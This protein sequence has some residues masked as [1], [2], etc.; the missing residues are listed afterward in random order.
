MFAF[1]TPFD[2][3]VLGTPPAFI[4]SQDRTLMFLSGFGLLSG[5][6]FQSVQFDILCFTC[7]WVGLPL[8]IGSALS[9]RFLSTVS[10]GLS[11]IFQ[12]C[13]A[14]YLSR[15]SSCSQLSLSAGVSCRRL[16]FKPSTEKEGFEPSRRY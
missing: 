2:L 4:L 5:F 3:H 13:I 10:R 1:G 14:V 11:G 12:V 16:I 15:C 9:S 8:L 6:F 7:F